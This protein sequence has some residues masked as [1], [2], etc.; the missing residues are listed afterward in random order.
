MNIAPARSIRY[1]TP[2][3]ASLLV[4]WA[5]VGQGWGDEREQDGAYAAI[6]FIGGRSA[7]RHFAAGRDRA[8]ELGIAVSYLIGRER[9]AWA[10]RYR[11]GPFRWT[12][13]DCHGRHRSTVCHGTGSSID[14]AAKL[15]GISS[16]N[17][18]LLPLD[19]AE[20]DVSSQRPARNGP[21]PD[22]CSQRT[23]IPSSIRSLGPS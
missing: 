2:L 21:E 9:S 17:I 1:A 18:E 11:A 6:G 10:V 5:L 7:S 4:G 13:Q 16:E 15:T 14:R 3:L 22:Q 12:H 19:D 8:N 23:T 20:L